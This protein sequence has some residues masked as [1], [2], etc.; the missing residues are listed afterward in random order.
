MLVVYPITTSAYRR[1]DGGWTSGDEEEDAPVAYLPHGGAPLL[2]YCF[3]DLISRP[4]RPPPVVKQR[5]HVAVGEQLLDFGKVVLPS[6]QAEP[7]ND[8]S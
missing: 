2:P 4:L 5:L 8:I 7:H 3:V 6:L 1:R